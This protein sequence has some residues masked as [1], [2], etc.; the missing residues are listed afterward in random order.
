[1]S[2]D[3]FWSRVRAEFWPKLNELDN[4]CESELGEKNSE[5]G[6]HLAKLEQNLAELGQNF[7]LS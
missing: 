7:V 1:M 4:F 5:L 6:Q 2:V 3:P